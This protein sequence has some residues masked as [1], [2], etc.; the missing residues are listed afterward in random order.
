MSMDL[1][2]ALIVPGVIGAAVLAGMYYL[3]GVCCDIIRDE[4]KA[5]DERRN[6]R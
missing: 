3:S 5:L 1:F 6:A 4:A 2:M